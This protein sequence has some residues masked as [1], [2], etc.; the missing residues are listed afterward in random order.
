[1]EEPG[2]YLAAVNCTTALSSGALYCGFVINTNLIFHIYLF[3]YKI[4]NFTVV[5][6]DDVAELQRYQDLWSCDNPV[7]VTDTERKMRTRAQRWR[8]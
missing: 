5:S 3:Q 7:K 4:L 2:G 1:M 8:H 6:E